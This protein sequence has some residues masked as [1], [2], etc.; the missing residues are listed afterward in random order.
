MKQS[1][2]QQQQQQQEVYHST[3]GGPHRSIG[4]SSVPST[5]ADD[6]PSIPSQTDKT[7]TIITSSGSYSSS[8]SQSVSSGSYFAS[9]SS[10][11][12]SSGFTPPSQSIVTG[13]FS[14]SS[15]SLSTSNSLKKTDDETSNTNVSEPPSSDDH[16]TT[17]TDDQGAGGPISTHCDADESAIA[18]SSNTNT[19][20][21]DEEIGKQDQ[22]LCDDRHHHHV[23]A[24]SSSSTTTT[25]LHMMSSSNDTL[26]PDTSHED[27]GG[28]DI[29]MGPP[30][31]IIHVPGNP[32]T[33]QDNSGPMSVKSPSRGGGGELMETESFNP[34]MNSPVHHA[35]STATASQNYSTHGDHTAGHN[36]TTD[37][38]ISVTMDTTSQ[39]GGD[40]S[41]CTAT[42]PGNTVIEVT[43]PLDDGNSIPSH[44]NT[45]DGTVG[46]PLG[47]STTST[48]GTIQ[49][50]QVDGGTDTPVSV[51]VAD[52]NNFSVTVGTS[53][54]VSV[55]PPVGQPVIPLDTSQPMVSDSTDQ[56]PIVGSHLSTSVLSSDTHSTTEVEDTHEGDTTISDDVRVGCTQESFALRLSPSQVLPSQVPSQ[57]FT[58]V[59]MAPVMSSS[60]TNTPQHQPMDVKD[61]GSHGNGS[62]DIVIDLTQTHSNAPL[63][64]L[65]NTLPFDPPTT[66]DLTE[67]DDAVVVS[68]TKSLQ[69]AT[70]DM[71]RNPNSSQATGS[72]SSIDCTSPMPKPVY[73]SMQYSPVDD[74]PPMVSKYVHP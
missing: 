69:S 15:S 28:T 50:S 22:S 54:P 12:G 38:R 53:Q 39:D 60:I 65:T 37:G 61:D 51:G 34:P 16:H 48:E 49:R 71:H 62:H 2:K 20:P 73:E 64:V 63:P 14:S 41:H 33:E 11:G 40:M 19:P 42:P 26:P 23:V 52:C 31:D 47:D 29:R 24:E 17:D 1:S 25:G 70:P 56:S 59:K 30:S 72:Q 7:P 6:S 43:Q 8:S 4:M 67:N 10:G 21:L 68:S 58:P 74:T 9:V 55:G 18:T 36:V 45:S 5:P 32:S 66:I 44:E 46:Q 57:G 13:E 27:K 3:P 35:A